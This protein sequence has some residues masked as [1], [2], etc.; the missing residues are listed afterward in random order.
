MMGV[1][2]AFGKKGVRQWGEFRGERDEREDLRGYDG[3]VFETSFS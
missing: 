2:A 1:K 3:M